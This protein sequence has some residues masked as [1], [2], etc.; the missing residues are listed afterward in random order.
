VTGEDE[1]DEDMLRHYAR[2]WFVDTLSLLAIESLGME[3]CTLRN[4]IWTKCLSEEMR[5]EHRHAISRKTLGTKRMMEAAIFR[6][7]MVGSIQVDE[8][9]CDRKTI[10]RRSPSQFIIE[11]KVMW[12][13]P[14][15]R[16]VY[17][18]SIDEGDSDTFSL[19]VRII[20]QPDCLCLPLPPLLR[21]LSDRVSI[22]MTSLR[23]VPVESPF[24]VMAQ[25]SFLL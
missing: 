6:D 2:D 15:T 3:E 5:P 25:S 17:I 8:E 13:D 22:L 21:S 1:D 20:S 24:L 10:L 9:I 12:Y 4:R 11:P 18:Q 23:S 7:V 14:G 16:R 19:R